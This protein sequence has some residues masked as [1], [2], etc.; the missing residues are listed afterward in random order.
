MKHI[1]QQKVV[2]LTTPVSFV[3][4]LEENK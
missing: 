1:N 4:L 2:I 3:T